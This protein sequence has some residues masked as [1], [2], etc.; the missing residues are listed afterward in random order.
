MDGS[1]ARAHQILILADKGVAPFPRKGG[2]RG[3]DS[4]SGLDLAFETGPAHYARRQPALEQDG[5]RFLQSRPI[6][7]PFYVIDG[8]G[9]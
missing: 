2:E 8:S 7:E 6:R 5:K 1:K 3:C 4:P 9:R